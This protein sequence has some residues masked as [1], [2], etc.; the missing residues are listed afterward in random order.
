MLLNQNL[1]GGILIIWNELKDKSLV[2]YESTPNQKTSLH[3]SVSN[4]NNPVFH[5]NITL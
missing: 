5:I 2:H 1:V 3:F 4:Q